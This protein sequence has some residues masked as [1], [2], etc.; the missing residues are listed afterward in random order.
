[1]DQRLDYQAVAPEAVAAYSKFNAYFEKCGVETPLLELIRTRVSQI[2]GCAHSLDMHTK[3]ARAGGETEQRLYTL[4]A[5]REAPF[6]SERERA[7]LAW[8]ESVTR[9]SKCVID[10]E[11]FQNVRKQFSEKEIVELTF[12]I[13]AIDGWNR[14]AVPFRI[15]VGSYESSKITGNAE[16]VRC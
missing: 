15:P 14:L 5:W 4:S 11:L 7:A 2:N 8:A 12:A 3:D 1:V 9:I 10:D 13:I 6:Y 16:S